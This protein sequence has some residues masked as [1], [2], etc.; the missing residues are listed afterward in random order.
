[1]R[2]K[3][4]NI[5][6]NTGLVVFSLWLSYIVIQLIGYY[7]LKNQRFMKFATAQPKEAADIWTFEDVKKFSSTQTRSGEISRVLLS[8]DLE[9]KVKTPKSSPKNPKLMMEPN[10][11]P[12]TLSGR[13]LKPLRN[14]LIPD[15]DETIL[16]KGKFTGNVKASSHVTTDFVGR[17]MTGNTPGPN[18]KKNIVFLG[19]SFTFGFGVNNEDSYPY[20]VREKTGLNVYNY[21]ISGTSPSVTL[22]ILKDLKADYLKDISQE[23]T[24][25][26]Y[27]LIPDHINRMIGTVLQF[28]HMPGSFDT[29]PYIFL[30]DD[31]L[32][33]LNNFS[34]DKT[35]RKHILKFLSRIHLMKVFWVDIPQIGQDEIELMARILQEIEK[36]VKANTPQVKNFKVAFYPLGGV[37]EKNYRALRDELVKRKLSV[38]DYSMLNTNSL[39]RPYNVLD[40]DSHPSPLAYDVYS[41]LLANDLRAQ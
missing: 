8:M 28:R 35:F 19:C 7:C 14:G 30:K 12:K 2:G 24:T 27:T 4:K 25:V 5:L 18:K 11:L 31:E 20:K 34:E 40:Y 3:L 17:R 33:I 22:K 1:M 9:K 41:S 15:L 26:I 32:E 39:L 21:G 6:I 29:A 13:P 23:D 38:L 10:D 36:E 37:G 16:L